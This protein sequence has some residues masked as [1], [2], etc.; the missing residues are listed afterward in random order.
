[1]ARGETLQRPCSRTTPV[2]F[3]TLVNSAMNVLD[4]LFRH[5]VGKAAVRRPLCLVESD[6]SRQ[7]LDGL[8]RH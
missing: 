2:G 8:P 4:R 3:L 7:L 6:V 1:M 5:A